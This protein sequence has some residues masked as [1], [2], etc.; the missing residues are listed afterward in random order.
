MPTNAD[1]AREWIRLYTEIIDF[2]E[3]ILARMREMSRTLPPEVRGE[4]DESNI[5]PMEELIARYRNRVDEL[6]QV[7]RS[8]F[9]AEEQPAG[10][11]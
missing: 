3:S 6:E 10:R 1:E 8:I 7:L 9:P 2:E 11:G 5:T 4:V